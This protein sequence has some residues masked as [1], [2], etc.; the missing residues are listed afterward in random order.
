MARVVA[1]VAARDEADRI[2]ETVEGLRRIVEVDEVVVLDDGS[3]DHTGELAR[4]AGAR[5]VRRPR[6]RGKG[7]ALEAGLQLIMGDV[8]LFADGDLGGS[9]VEVAPV[10]RAVLED[11]ADLAVAVLPRPPVGGFG[12]VKRAAALSIRLLTGLAVR[13]PLSGQRA[14]TARALTACRPLAGGFGIETAMTIDAARA[15]FRVLEVPIAAT[16]RPTGRDLRGFVHRGRQ[17][18]DVLRAVAPR[19]RPTRP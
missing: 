16:H 19:V 5:V 7:S 11:R 1:M 10:L 9:S 12:V 17:G 4:R 13:E 3:R 2:Q 14:I 6:S 18:L 15:G 8:Y